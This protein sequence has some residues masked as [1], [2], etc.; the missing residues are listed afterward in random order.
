MASFKMDFISMELNYN[1]LES[2]WNIM[3]LNSFALKLL[4]PY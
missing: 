4:D 1:K 2:E 3:N